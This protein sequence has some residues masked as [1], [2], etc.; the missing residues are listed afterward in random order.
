MEMGEG[1]LDDR[2]GLLDENIK[3]ERIIDCKRPIKYADKSYSAIY[4]CIFGESNSEAYESQLRFGAR[5]NLKFL[6]KWHGV[7]YED[8]TF[9]DEFIIM[10]YKNILK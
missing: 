4:E 6:V 2:S 5:S 9:E 8:S 3:I 10:R 7:F 1:S